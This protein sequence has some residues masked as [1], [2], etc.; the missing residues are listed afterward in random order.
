MGLETS[1]GW[2]NATF[3]PWRGCERVSAGCLHCYAEAGSKRNTRTLGVW[4]GEK[5]G[6]TR[7]VASEN[8]WKEIRKYDFASRAPAI[9]PRVFV[10]SYADWLEEWRGPMLNAKGERLLVGP[11]G[12]WVGIDKETE[13][14]PTLRN[15]ES[16]WLSMSAV[17]AELLKLVI[18]CRNLNFLL[19]TK[20]IENFNRLIWEACESLRLEEA[21]E[22]NALNVAEFDE[23]HPNA[24]IGTTVEN[25]KAFHRIEAL[26]NSY[27][28]VVKFLSVEPLI[29]EVRFPSLKGI[30]WV[31]LG[32]ESGPNARPCNVEWI[33]SALHQC[34]DA[35]VKVFVKQLGSKPFSI[36]DKI[37]YWNRDRDALPKFPDGFYRHL[38]HS[39][40]EDA[41]EW[42]V[43]LMVQEFP[44]PRTFG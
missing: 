2:T 26:R 41:A 7:V 12:E 16:E 5:A 1:I 34:H 20:R 22:P 10:A 31:I 4:G 25:P 28:A 17:R 3:N 8:K 9:P 38:R 6:G 13:N 11:H 24:W 40:G 15:T 36:V 27:P 33:R 21:G 43:D 14:D 35:G 39:K 30:D 19:L 29:E 18:E 32:G 37:S 44:T 23:L 42:P